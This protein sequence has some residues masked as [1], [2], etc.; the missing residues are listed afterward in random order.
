MP[1]VLIGLS[2]LILVSTYLYAWDHEIHYLMIQ[3]FPLVPPISVDDGATPMN[4][5]HNYTLTC[6]TYGINVTTYQW[7]KDN[8]ILTETGPTLLFSPLG[9]SDACLLYTSDAADE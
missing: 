3:L 5:G 4:I 9:L 6:N 8:I 1:L 7:R 2:A